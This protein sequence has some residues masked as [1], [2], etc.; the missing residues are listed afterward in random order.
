M[1]CRAAILLGWCT[2]QCRS[3]LV[4]AS[5]TSAFVSSFTLR[6]NPVGLKSKRVCSSVPGLQSCLPRIYAPAS[7]SVAFAAAA[8]LA[9]AFGR[10]HLVV[11]EPPPAGQQME[12]DAVIFLEHGS[13][14]ELLRAGERAGGGLRSELLDVLQNQCAQDA[15]RR[16][17]LVSKRRLTNPFM[18][19]EEGWWD[20]GY[21]RE[22]R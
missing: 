21:W 18:Q 9:A 10:E 20:T 3:S 8:Q 13:G 6:P 4:P 12:K 2:S 11:E 15:L 14:V 7:D 5:E 17:A 22:K 16:D 19:G 1:N